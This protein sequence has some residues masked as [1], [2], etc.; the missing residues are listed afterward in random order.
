MIDRTELLEAALDSRPD[1]IALLDGDGEIVFWNRAAEAITGFT[2]IEV[3]ARPIPAPLG[4]LLFDSALQEDLP[5]GTA[6]PALGGALVHALH[7]LGHSVP[8]IA[9]RVVLRN[10]IGERIGLAVAFH[11]AASLGALPGGELCEEI[12]EN[13]SRAELE[14]KLQIEFDDF[15]RGGPPFG[16]LWI[17]V[18]QNSDLHKTHGLGACRAML[19]KVHRA[20]A[21]GLRP[22]DQMGRWC[23]AEFLVVAHERSAQMLAAHAQTLVG[24]ARVADFRWWGDR[25]S[26]TVSIGAAQVSRT[27][28]ETLPQLLERAHQAMETSIRVGGNRLTAAAFA[29]SAAEAEEDSACSPS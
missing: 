23:D 29:D 9:R 24:L 22:T 28:G 11:P 1:G 25:I 19:E 8:A 27:A 14:E 16:I 2:G 10:G 20:L 5:L 4:P 3:L 26:L 7:K 21:Q 13:D 18:D 6:P 17:S 15:S 12:S